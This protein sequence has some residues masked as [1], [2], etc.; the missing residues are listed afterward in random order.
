M[1]PAKEMLDIFCRMFG[2]A[3][4]HIGEPGLGI[5]IVH[6]GGDDQAIDGGGSGPAA[7]RTGEQ[8]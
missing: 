3:G 6:L 7:I 5:D 8:P 2:D 4:Q 1:H